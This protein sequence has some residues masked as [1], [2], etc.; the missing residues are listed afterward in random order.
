MYKIII[1]FIFLF[2]S[3]PAHAIDGA[4]LLKQVDRNL[5]PESYESYR[6]LINIEPDGRKKEFITDRGQHVALYPERGQADPHNKPS[7]HRRRGL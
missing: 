5:N 7:V 1:T 6:K 2:L 3:T 4:E